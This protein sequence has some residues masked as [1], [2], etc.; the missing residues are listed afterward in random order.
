MCFFSPKRFVK[1][2]FVDSANKI[3]GLKVRKR[4]YTFSTI[5]TLECGI[6]ELPL[7][8][9]IPMDEM[10]I[11]RIVAES[12]SVIA[13]VILLKFMVKP[14]TATR[15]GRYIG[16]PLGFGFLGA[17]YALSAI[18][19]IHPTF[20]DSDVN[21][22]KWVQ[23]LFRAFS[24]LFLAVTYYFSKKPSKNTRYIWDIVFSGIFVCLVALLLAYFVVP[25]IPLSNYLTINIFARISNI[26]CLSYIFIHCFREHAKEPDP[27]SAWVITGYALLGLSQFLYLILYFYLGTPGNFA[28]WVSVT[29]RLM[30]LSIFLFTAHQT[31][32]KFKRAMVNEDPKKR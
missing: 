21:G 3:H 26:V 27:I 31:F 2:N 9:L 22:I 24:F 5:A 11:A 12:I 1:K 10:I 7:D 23:L 25:Q 14:Y 8:V 29:L 15:E 30:S 28:F 18:A 17:S 6:V 4:K 20:Y 13:C 32:I 19:Y 16:L